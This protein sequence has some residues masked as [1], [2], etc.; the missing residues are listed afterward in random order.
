MSTLLPHV[1]T[2][3]LDLG[4]ATGNVVAGIWG[5][6]KAFLPVSGQITGGVVKLTA[7]FREWGQSLSGGTGFQSLMTTFRDGDAAGRSRS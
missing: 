4:H 6:L 3:I 2:T 7:K 1:R 5:I